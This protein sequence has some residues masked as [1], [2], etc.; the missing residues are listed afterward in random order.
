MK[1]II[2]L[3]EIIQ[4]KKRIHD[5]I[6]HTPLEYSENLSRI[7]HTDIYLKLENFQVTGSFKARGAFNKVLTLPQNDQ[8]SGV[9]AP[10]AGNHGIGLGFAAKKLNM[11]AHIYL[12][13]DADPSKVTMLESYGVK[14]KFFPSIEAARQSAL[15]DAK[16]NRLTFVSAYNDEAMIAAGGTVGLEIVN[17]L[18]DVDIVIAG[19]GG[20]GLTSGICIALKSINPNIQI[21]GVQT[22]NSPTIAVWYQQGRATSVNL[23]P[24]IAEGLSGPIEPETITFPIILRYMDR[25]ITVS[26]EDIVMGMKRLLHANYMVEPSGA[27]GVAALKYGEHE[28]K[29]KK[30]VVVVT[31]RNVSWSRFKNLVEK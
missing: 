5:Y 18:S 28:L 26:D 7:H 23:K 14:L 19:I 12:P 9:I 13:E 11:E 22:A 17:D 27:A 6:H 16:E 3:Q 10:S 24:S 4:T 31:G 1:K 30:V 29:G 8:N 20:G 2:T 15:L 25:I 21:W